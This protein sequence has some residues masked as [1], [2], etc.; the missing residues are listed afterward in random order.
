MLYWLALVHN[1]GERIEHMINYLVKSLLRSLPPYQLNQSE[2]NM[3]LVQ[4]GHSETP[5]Q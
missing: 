4:S 1:L 2:D 3:F 5:S